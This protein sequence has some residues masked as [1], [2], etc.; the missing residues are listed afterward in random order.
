[1][2]GRLFPEKASGIPET[3][4]QA[5]AVCFCCNSSKVCTVSSARTLPFDPTLDFAV[6]TQEE[7]RIYTGS[8]EYSMLLHMADKHFVYE[9]M[10]LG[11]ELTPFNTLGHIA[12]VHYVAMHAAGSLPLCTFHWI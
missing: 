5:A 9:F 6:L 7:R 12:G 2:L 3:P 8:G 4:E 11:I 1:M 10:R